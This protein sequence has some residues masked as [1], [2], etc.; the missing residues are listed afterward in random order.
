MTTHLQVREALAEAL[1]ALDG[2]TISAGYRQITNQGEG[3]VRFA[4]RVRDGSGYGYINTWEI[5]IA[6][7][8]DV[9]TGET[10]LDDHVNEITD[11]L[12]P[13]LMVLTGVTPAQLALGANPING[14]IFAGV[15][16][17]D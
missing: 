2:L 14:V 3:F 15:R 10:W 8:Q 7:S 6:L 11:A 12:S 5:W 17:H 1:T 4:G 13:H 16:E 9:P